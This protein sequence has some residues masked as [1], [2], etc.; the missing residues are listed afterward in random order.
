MV[1][2]DPWNVIEKN[3]ENTHN[4][5][6]NSNESNANPSAFE[7]NFL[8]QTAANVS[9]D[10]LPDSKEYIQALGILLLLLLSN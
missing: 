4:C 8:A 9:N 5:V 2:P 10:N 7:D 6:T 1:E 3:Q